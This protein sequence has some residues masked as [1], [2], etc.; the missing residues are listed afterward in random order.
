[1]AAFGMRVFADLGFSQHTNFAGQRMAG[2]GQ[3]VTAK[4]GNTAALAKSSEKVQSSFRGSFRLASPGNILYRRHPV[5]GG[6]RGFGTGGV[7]MF[8]FWQ[9]FSNLSRRPRRPASAPRTRLNCEAM[10]ERAVPSAGSLDASFGSGGKVLLYDNVIAPTGSGMIDGAA[11]LQSD[12]PMFFVW[13]LPSP[14]HRLQ[15]SPHH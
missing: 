15:L 14:T 4:M 5:S 9:H 11:S 7:L 12:G 3:F 2:A 6:N 13:S 8:Q 1:M 10:E